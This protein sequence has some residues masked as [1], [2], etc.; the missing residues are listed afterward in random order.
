ML[1]GRRC[2]RCRLMGRYARVRVA[3]G[4]GLCGQQA[5][6]GGGA[7]VVAGGAPVWISS[8]NNISPNPCVPV[9]EY[10]IDHAGGGGILNHLSNTPADGTFLSGQPGGSFYRV[11]GGAPLAVTDCG[12]L[13]GCLSPVAVDQVAITNAGG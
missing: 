1:G 2:V 11:A 5:G 13:G 10:A 9:D 3:D 6:G 7:F 12:A 8:F 4:T